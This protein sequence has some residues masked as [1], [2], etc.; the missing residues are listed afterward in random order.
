K[1]PGDM[2][3]EFTDIEPSSTKPSSTGS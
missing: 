1:I 3:D 2:K